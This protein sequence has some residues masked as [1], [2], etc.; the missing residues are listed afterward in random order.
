MTVSYSA[1]LESFRALLFRWKGSLWRSVGLELIVWLLIYGIISVVY[2][3]VFTDE[4]KRMYE[5]VAGRF[6]AA[7]G[8]IP[9]QFNLGFYV[10]S[11]MSR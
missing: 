11:V 7:L 6:E 3:I 10:A 9:V 8:L 4:Q 1:G 2:R 5:L